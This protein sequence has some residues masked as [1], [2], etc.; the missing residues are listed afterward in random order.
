MPSRGV[1]QLYRFYEG[2]RNTMIAPRV[3][4]TILVYIAAHNN[5]ENIGQR[6]LDQLLGVGSTPQLKLAALYDQCIGATRCIVG[7]PGQAAIEESLNDFDSGDP[8]ALLET[9]R[10]AFEQCPAERYAWINASC[11]TSAASAA[12]ATWDATKLRTRGPYLSMTSPKASVSPAA[13]RC[14]STASGRGTGSPPW[15]QLRLQG[16]SSARTGLLQNLRAGDLQRRERQSPV[17]SLGSRVN[18]ERRERQ[19]ASRHVHKLQVG[20]G[21]A[22]GSLRVC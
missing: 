8:D 7:N 2:E 21:T 5:L 20:C 19:L 6:S 3:Q 10:W 11:V 9:V 22:D 14:N 16:Y 12:D 17:S 13:A 1:N 18:G 4:W 15:M